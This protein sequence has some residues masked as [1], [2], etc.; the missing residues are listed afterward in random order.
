MIDSLPRKRSDGQISFEDQI[1][2][3]GRLRLASLIILGLSVIFGILATIL[4]AFASLPGGFL[5]SPDPVGV[6]LQFSFLGSI[7]SVIG[8]M[9]VLLTH[10]K[11]GGYLLV[12]GSVLQVIFAVHVGITYANMATVGAFFAVPFSILIGIILKAWRYL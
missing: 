2:W 11:F 3:R 10:A 6:S 5:H 9:V 12:A 1:K 8:A 7:V 4:L